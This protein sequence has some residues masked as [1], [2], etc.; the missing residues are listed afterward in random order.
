MTDWSA[1]HRKLE[2]MYLAAPTNEYFRPR[3]EIAEGTCTITLPVRED[4]FHAARAVH[5]AVYF[6]TLDDAAF[7][8]A[9]SVVPDVFVLTA[10]LE[11]QFLQPIREGE[12]VAT[13]TL[14]DAGD[15]VLEARGEVRDSHGDLI[16]TGGGA[17]VKSQ[18]PLSEDIGYV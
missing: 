3:I 7:F 17:F 18:T 11:I 12:L 9:N 4:F 2:R 15:R 8:A 16:A 10:S 14:V 1:H 5:G 13:G 6:K